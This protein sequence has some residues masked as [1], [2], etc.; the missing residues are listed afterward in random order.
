MAGD[1]DNNILLALKIGK[2]VGKV[3]FSLFLSELL[4]KSA[5]CVGSCS[6]KLWTVEGKFAQVVLD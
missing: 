2:S 6:P 1:N 3:H 5:H 4:M